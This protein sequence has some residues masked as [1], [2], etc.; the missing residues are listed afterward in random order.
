M[1]VH[2]FVQIDLEKWNF[3]VSKQLRGERDN[4][5]SLLIGLEEKHPLKHKFHAR[6][7]RRYKHTRTNS[8]RRSSLPRVSRNALPK[9]EPC[10]TLRK[11]VAKEISVSFALIK[12]I[13]FLFSCSLVSLCH[14]TY[15]TILCNFDDLEN[16]PRNCS[17][18]PHWNYPIQT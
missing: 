12:S 6:S 16:E 4:K 14:C 1:W 18:N 17:F 10:V 2:C 13:N 9:R 8:L 3:Q 15:A 7:W 11:T 5:P